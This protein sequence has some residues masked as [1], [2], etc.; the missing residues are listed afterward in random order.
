METWLWTGL[1][2]SLLQ[3]KSIIHQQARS[4]K[5][6]LEAL[7]GILGRDKGQEQTPQA[8]S[9]NEEEGWLLW[10]AQGESSVE[11]TLLSPA[12]APPSQC[13]CSTPA[14]HPHPL[15]QQGQDRQGSSLPHLNHPTTASITGIYESPL[16][17][18]KWLDVN[19]PS[20]KP[21]RRFSLQNFQITCVNCVTPS[22]HVPKRPT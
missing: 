6:H 19:V 4:T 3:T 1:Y 9:F 7:V 15:H 8:T 14:P 11:P 20:K 18:K 21:Q 2:P 22:Q 13:L 16:L 10:G 5:S 12:T 17:A